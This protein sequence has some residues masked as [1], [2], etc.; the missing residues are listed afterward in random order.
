MIATSIVLFSVV[1]FDS[2]RCM[3]VKDSRSPETR[4]PKARPSRSQFPEF[5]QLMIATQE[6]LSRGDI[7]CVAVGISIAQW[8]VRPPGRAGV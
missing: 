1:M 5:N 7:F 3:P 8:D 6:K 4:G 2:A